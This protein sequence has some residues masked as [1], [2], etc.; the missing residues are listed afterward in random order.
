MSV[1]LAPPLL[2]GSGTFSVATWN[3]RSTRGVGLAVV[4]KG[5]HQIGVGCAVLT[6]TKLTNDQY[7][8]HIGG[9]HMI[10]SKATSTQQGGDCPALDSRASGL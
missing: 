7:P 6:K 1:L 8:K 2:G 5:L 3:I 9:Y 10:A 4:A